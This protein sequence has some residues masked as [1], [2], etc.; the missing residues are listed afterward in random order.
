MKKKL[1][2]FIPILAFLIIGISSL[3]R[4]S[5]IDN[6]QPAAGSLAQSTPVRGN[7]VKAKTDIEALEAKHPATTTNKFAAF[8]S[9]GAALRDGTCSYLSSSTSAGMSCSVNDSGTAFSLTQSGTGSIAKLANA[10]S[11]G[12]TIANS[13]AVSLSTVSTYVPLTITQSGTSSTASLVLNYA[14]VP[15]F[16]FYNDGSFNGTLLSSVSES[17]PLDIGENYFSFLR[18][19][20]AGNPQSKTLDNTESATANVFNLRNYSFDY[21]SVTSGWPDLNGINLVLNPTSTSDKTT[22]SSQLTSAK[23]TMNMSN[24]LDG[25]IEDSG[26]VGHAGVSAPLVFPES[27]TTTTNYSSGNWQGVGYAGFRT[28]FMGNGTK[29]TSGNGMTFFGM[30]IG[31]NDTYGYNSESYMLENDEFAGLAIAPVETPNADIDYKPIWIAGAGNEADTKGRSY[32]E[33]K[34][35]IG[36]SPDWDGTE[37]VDDEVSWCHNSAWFA[38]GRNQTGVGSNEK[39]GYFY[40]NSTTSSTSN[41]QH[42]VTADAGDGAWAGPSVAFY[43]ISGNDSLTDHCDSLSD[44]CYAFFAEGGKIRQETRFSR[45]S[46]TAD[47]EETVVTCE[48]SPCATLTVEMPEAKIIKAVTARQKNYSESAVRWKIGITGNDDLFADN[49]TVSQNCTPATYTESW[50]PKM[51]TT[52]DSTQIILTPMSGSFAV[53]T[54]IVVAI[55]VDSFTHP[56]VSQ[57]TF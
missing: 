23:F 42:L 51:Y 38:V 40:S 33:P 50:T 26:Y 44:S 13:G 15:K 31:G 18:G 4:A 6:T 47:I 1:S 22:F 53:G 36:C 7:F 5:T 11:Y 32:H 19:A 9:T 10:S 16:T 48:G 12:L 8:S 34:F 57:T 29:R 24:E 25:F 45:A 2:I 37:G 17:W 27:S 28:G 35:A 46:I 14:A 20:E 55:F 21:S 30:I 49:L 43:A 3:L 39:L 56:V 52:G 41:Y 54:E